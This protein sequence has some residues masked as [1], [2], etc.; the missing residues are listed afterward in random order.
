MFPCLIEVT[1]VDLCVL[2]GFV[3]VYIN[4]QNLKFNQDNPQ[5]WRNVFLI[6]VAFVAALSQIALYNGPQYIG[7]I[8]AKETSKFSLFSFGDVILPELARNLPHYNLKCDLKRIITDS[9][10]AL[11]NIMAMCSIISELQSTLEKMKEDDRFEELPWDF[12]NENASTD[13]ISQMHKHFRYGVA[14]AAEDTMAS[15]PPDVENGHD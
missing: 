12:F 6:Y 7:L 10:S 15:N 14:H 3:Q 8:T 1:V 13:E 2:L 4:Y 9:G 11:S 5:S